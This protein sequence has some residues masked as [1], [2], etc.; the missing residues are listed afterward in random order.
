MNSAF[1][2]NILYRFK[3]RKQNED[4][5]H[6]TWN[7]DGVPILKSSKFS[8]WPL[9]LVINELLY[10]LRMLKENTLFGGLWFGEIKANMQLFH[11]C[12]LSYQI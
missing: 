11:L 1:A 2:N 5:P 4:V 12:S 3:R 8:V 9:Y 10:D 7:V 6:L